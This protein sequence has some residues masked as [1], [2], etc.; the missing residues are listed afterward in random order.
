MKF[1]K[2]YEPADFE[3]EVYAL[4]EQSGT[5]APQPAKEGKGNYCIVMPP[6]NA[7]GN[8]HIGH[9]L[10]TAVEDVLIRYHR[11]HGDST[12]WI[13]GADHA[14]FETWVV[15]EKVL[16]SQGKT[17]FDF[18]RDELYQQTWDFVAAQ[19]GNM[20]LQLR[21]LGASCDWSSLVFTL[22]GKVV[23]RVYDTFKKLWQDGLI[24]RGERLVNFCPVHQT[25]F[26]DIEVDH[27]E[28]K[29]TLWDIAYPLADGEGEIIVSTTRP[30][31]MLG[32]TAVAVHPDDSRYQKYVGKEVI[33]PLTG[34]QIPI[35]T[36]TYVDREY[37]SGAVKITPAHDQ[38][39]YDIGERHGLPM[40]SIIG[41]DGTMTENAGEAYVGMTVEDARHQVLADLEAQGLR[42]GETTIIHSVGHCYKCGSV[43]EPLLKE[44]WFVHIRP[45]AD[46]A[47][48]AIRSGK[49]K[50]TPKSKK[51]V[52]INY[53]KQLRD[54]N[55]SR[56]IP[57][58]IPIPAFQN[59]EDP[60]DWIFSTEVTKQTLDINGKTYKRDEDT[61]DTWFS[62]GQWPVVV[63][64][65]H[66]EFYPTSVMETA[67]DILFSWVSRMIML[68]LYLTDEVPFH[69]VYLHGLVLDEHGVKMSKS[70][71]NV[72]NPME[73]ISE[74]GS[75]ALRLG[76]IAN[77]SAGQAQAFS[78]ASVVAGR[79][80][81]NK[82]WNI[83]RRIQQFVDDTGDT[84]DAN[85]D[86]V[87]LE[88]MSIKN[89]NEATIKA[90]HEELHFS[91]VKTE[92]MGE[93]WIVRELEDCRI[94]LDQLIKQY[95]F[96]EAEKLLYDTIWYKYADWFL[97][98]QKIY[99][100]IPLL[101]KTL[102]HLLL[103]LHPFAPFATETIWQTLSWTW[104]TAISQGMPGKLNYS[105]AKASEFDE[106]ILIISETRK[107]LSS[108]QIP[109]KPTLV[110]EGDTLVANNQ[111][112][113]TALARVAAVT[114]TDTPSG[115]RVP[116]PSHEL[117]LDI[118]Q[119]T[120]DKHRQQLEDR[121]LSLGAEIDTLNAR[122]DNPNY[123]K[124]A[125]KAL[126]EQTK[127]QIS[128]K[129]TLLEK[130]KEEFTSF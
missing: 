102:E 47:I 112:I 2:S 8:L 42:R 109:K 48:A 6:P 118:P 21:A 72:I 106:L 113:I 10:F 46:R 104:G 62:S 37:G 130:L 123:L 85:K 65:G 111:L 115:L 56:Q 15:Y 59:T 32:D 71:G 31:T 73:I 96:A 121:I 100:N 29:G 44:Q 107:V 77:R 53:Y 126:V 30:E 105:A 5:F 55:I 24:Y 3:P 54:W 129:Q 1:A 83:A 84:Y 50:F 98:S 28:A 13:P 103:M 26:A 39:D 20:E 64:D 49:I 45:L 67:A 117:F 4:W 95:Q 19:R 36:D 66:P 60:T 23:D 25:A 99:K 58:G 124:K 11:L 69:D 89:P 81:C 120:I 70:K 116:V 92:S 51:Q 18:S 40:I 78:R 110:F 82:L 88:R 80:L 75:D 86:P 79:N 90:A 91:K 22:D 57:W 27:D 127:S 16:E 38:N 14:G 41:F 35:I 94:K 76:L 61:F 68:G 7:N 114:R 12:W 87:A 93:D 43:L 125:P 9:A 52:L 17:R 33:L 128:E 108:L 34:R 101:K 63:T 97:E 74:Y 122:L 119:T